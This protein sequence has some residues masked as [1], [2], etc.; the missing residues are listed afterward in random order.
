[1]SEMSNADGEQRIH[2]I[3]A[4]LATTAHHKYQQHRL[5]EGQQQQLGGDACQVDIH[6]TIHKFIHFVF[7]LS[8]DSIEL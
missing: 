1:M 2:N 4:T 7:A 3:D 8:I 5:P 6:L